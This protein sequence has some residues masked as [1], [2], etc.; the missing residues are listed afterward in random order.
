MKEVNYARKQM[1]SV[2]EG[3]VINAD[4]FQVCILPG[5]SESTK[6]VF[7][8]KGHESFGARPSNLI[9]KFKQV[10]LQN[11]ERRGND[12]VYTHTLTL[13]EALQ[14]QPIAVDSLDNRKVFVAPQEV[15]T[16]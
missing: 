4:R 11:Y 6:L 7:E 13:V 10:P 16:P 14:M 2:T 3:S 12:L 5:F 1:L 8:G 9:V 15:I